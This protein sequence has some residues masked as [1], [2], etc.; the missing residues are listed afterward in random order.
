M[1]LL[2]FSSG[3]YPDGGAS[4][5]RHL[6]YAKGL[7][8]LGHSVEFILL[9][10]QNWIGSEF[11]TAGIKFTKATDKP[12][13]STSKIER[14]KYFFIA[15]RSAKKMLKTADDAGTIDAIILLDAGSTVL[16]PL[17]R[18]GKKLGIKIFHE[19]TEYPFVVADKSLYGKLDLYIYLRFV[20]H[21][22]DGIYVINNALKKYFSEKTKNKIPVRIINMIVDPARFELTKKEKNGSETKTITYCGK[23]EGDKDGVPILIEAFSMVSGEFPSLQLRLVGA[24]SDEAS[25]RH[26]SDLIVKYGIEGRVTLDGPYKR[27]EIPAILKDSDFL[28]LARPDNSQAEG[29]FPTKLGEY[30][31]TGNPAI[32]T[33]VGEIGLFLKDKVNA[34]VA[35]PDS[36][37]G[38][39]AKIRE[40]LLDD[41]AEKIGLA[42]KELVYNEFNYLKQAEKLEKMIIDVR[43]NHPF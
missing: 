6:A 33:N 12:L 31:A 14:I 11:V 37:S 23:F 21:M 42:G 34:Y 43:D 30:L 1:R 2:F 22:F 17:L 39:A 29:G 18:T 25:R 27:D 5:N 16:L 20:I 28:A 35:E 8:E 32:V 26:L 9:Q 4:T 38:F 19:R 41:S 36:P 7:V 10:P 40:A 3:P 15:I 13:S 24:M